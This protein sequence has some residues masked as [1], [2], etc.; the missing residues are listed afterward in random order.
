MNYLINF[1]L[2]KIINILLIRCT[3]EYFN[4]QSFPARHKPHEL[5]SLFVRE[6]RDRLPEEFHPIV[7]K[8]QVVLVLDRHLQVLDTY[9]RRATYFQ[10]ELRPGQ[11]VKHMLGNH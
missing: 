1:V 9:L 7:R 2:N 6:V 11:N 10:L 3:E 5:A 4:R 8:R